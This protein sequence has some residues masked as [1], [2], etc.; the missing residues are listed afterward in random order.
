MHGYV[1]LI[2]FFSGILV[3]CSSDKTDLGYLSDGFRL[4]FATVRLENAVP[5]LALDNKDT[6]RD[7]T[8]TS[9]GFTKKDGQRVLVNYSPAE[10]NSMAIHSVSDI[11]TSRIFTARLDTLGADPVKIQSIWIAGGYLNLILYMDYY[12]KKHQFGLY[13]SQQ[14]PNALY[15]SH[16]KQGDSQGYPL[17]IYMSF[18]LNGLQKTDDSGTSLSVSVPTASGI[19][20]Y[21]F[22]FL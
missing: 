18:Y 8:I 12:S 19:K 7:K 21:H 16:D 9:F 22:T 3:S 4:D 17:R 10:G 20:D 6:L 13:R 15:L 5:V 11:L 2:M 1:F 14:S